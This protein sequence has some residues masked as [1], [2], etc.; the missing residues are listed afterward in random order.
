MNENVKFLEELKQNLNKML[1][2]LNENPSTEKLFDF[3]RS[4]DVYS[5]LYYEEYGVKPNK[6]IA[7]FKKRLS[8]ELKT[9]HWNIPKSY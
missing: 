8:K 9:N 2:S 6:D 7:S 5:D 1:K 4:L 3:E